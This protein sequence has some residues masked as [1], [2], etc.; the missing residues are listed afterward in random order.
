MNMYAVRTSILLGLSFALL[1]GCSGDRR[2][3][4][5]RDIPSAATR[6]PATNEMA[7]PGVPGAYPYDLWIGS[8]LY[9]VEQEPERERLRVELVQWSNGPYGGRDAVFRVTNPGGPSV[10]VWNVRQQVRLPGSAQT[11]RAWETQRSDYPGRGWQDAVLP[12]GGSAEFPLPA[13]FDGDWRVCL[14]YSREMPG[15]EAPNRR[16]D[17]TYEAIGPS[18]REPE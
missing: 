6:P 5:S 9:R 10:L 16:F 2:G 1:T 15:S 12:P 4:S 3:R 11:P 8:S 7:A 18:V 17:G 14:L 13:S